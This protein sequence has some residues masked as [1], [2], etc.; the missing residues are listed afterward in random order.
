MKPHK[1]FIV[2]VL[3]ALVVL[4]APPIGA[5]ET[6]LTTILT[7]ATVIDATGA[8]PRADSTVV[9]RGNRIVEIRAGRYQ[10]PEGDGVR[11]F[12]LQGGYILPGLWNNHSHLSDLLPDPHN[13]LVGEPVLQAA[14]RAGR[15]AMDALR[16]GFTSLRMTG[17][18]DY[19]DVAWRD[20]FDAGVFVGPRIIASGNP[21]TATGGHGADGIGV[22]AIEI[23]GPFEMRRA[24]R[25]NIKNGADFIKIMVDELQPD[26]I[27]AAIETAH[28]YGVKVTGHAREPGARIAVELGIDSIEH[29]YGLTDETLRLMAEKGTFYDPTIVCNLSAEYIS[30]R[31]ARIAELGLDEDPLAIEG[32]ILVA[33]AD[34]RSPRN[35]ARQREI[36]LKA[37]AAGVKVI[38]GSDSNPIDE[39]GRLEIE[40]LV[41]SGISE[42]DALIA[43]TRNSADMVGLLDQVGTVEEGKIADLIVLA[44]N[45]LDHISNIRKLMMVFKDGLP[46]NLARDEGQTSFWEL[47]FR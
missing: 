11:V 38:T 40:Q 14:I 27:R 41:F 21:I 16:A 46:V 36:L 25:E 47:Y 30:E 29:G 2:A 43:A 20:A 10:G 44:G 8:P 17:E 39:I 6:A 18:R 3:C 12:D 13:I 37:V 9:I 45:P 28:Q 4:P 42:M 1:L 33:Y 31:E 15:N 22:V 35:A 7:N 26:E 32:R 23:D 19:I 5:Q 34:E 24:V